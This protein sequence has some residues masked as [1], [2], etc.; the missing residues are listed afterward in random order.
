MKSFDIANIEGTLILISCYTHELNDQDI[1]YYRV[2]PH[3]I[4]NGEFRNFEL[5]GDGEDIDNNFPM[6]QF[7]ERPLWDID[8]GLFDTVDEV[9]D[10]ILRTDGKE[11]IDA[12]YGDEEVVIDNKLTITIYDHNRDEVYSTSKR[13]NIKRTTPETTEE[14]PSKEAI[15]RSIDALVN[16]DEEIF[17]HDRRIVYHHL[18]L[19]LV[20]TVIVWLMGYSAG[21]STNGRLIISILSGLYITQLWWSNIPRKLFGDRVWNNKVRRASGRP[22]INGG[23]LAGAGLTSVMVAV[24]RLCG[25]DNNFTHYYLF[26]LSIAICMTIII[27]AVNRGSNNTKPFSTYKGRNWFMGD[28]PNKQR[29]NFWKEFLSRM[30]P[31]NW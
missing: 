31:W 24:D 4:R 29:R 26:F 22:W 8:L 21:W 12:L 13:F 6:E 23:A 25:N 16:Y 27:F 9:A 3:T 17:L 2:L 10:Y 18:G 14:T 15:Q 11:I 19:A 20:V 30:L 5:D 7:S 28:F 1:R